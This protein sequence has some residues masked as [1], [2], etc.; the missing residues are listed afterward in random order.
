M[1]DWLGSLK[2]KFILS[3]SDCSEIRDVF[4]AFH[5]EEVKLKYS[6]AS[7]GTTDAAE[8]LVTNQRAETRL[9]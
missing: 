2:G 5:F 6:V 7:S 3:I 1:A 9:L 8:L 4:S